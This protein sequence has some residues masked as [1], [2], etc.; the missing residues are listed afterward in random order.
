MSVRFHCERATLYRLFRT[1]GHLCA[2]LAYKV[3][4]DAA[5]PEYR[6]TA[7]DGEL[8]LAGNFWRMAKALIG[9][10]LRSIPRSLERFSERAR[11][12]K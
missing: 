3:D 9:Y 7:V 10:R 1:A 5:L 4:P 2:A 12:I 11:G 8:Y 6:R